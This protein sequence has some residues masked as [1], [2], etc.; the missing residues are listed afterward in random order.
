MTTIGGPVTC[1]ACLARR[2]RAAR[3]H[4]HRRR[5]AGCSSRCAERGGG[6]RSSTAVSP[7]DVQDALAAFSGKV[8]LVRRPD[9]RR[10]G[11]GHPRPLARNRAARRPGRELGSLADLPKT[12]LE[13]GDGGRRADLSRL[14]PRTPRCVLRPARPAA[15]RRAE[16]AAVADRSSGSPRTSAATASRPTS[17]CSRTGSSSDGF[18]SSARPTSSSLRDGRPD[19]ARPLSRPDDLRAARAGGRDRHPLDHGCGRDRRPSA[20]RPRRRSRHLRDA[21]RATSPFASSSVR[22]R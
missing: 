17:S 6:T 12:D 9:R 5:R 3:R 1:S 4:G 13:A 19:P 2:R 11:D 15:L 18:P 22:G 10:R 20:R 21:R 14:R 7:A 8:L 16:R